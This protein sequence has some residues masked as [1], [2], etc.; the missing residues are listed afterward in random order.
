MPCLC[1]GSSKVA[2]VDDAHVHHRTLADF[3]EA[4]GPPVSAPPVDGPGERAVV[5]GR[6]SMG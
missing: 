3:P 2:P 6:F 1:G 5:G 4:A